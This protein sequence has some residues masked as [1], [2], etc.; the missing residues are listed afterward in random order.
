[1]NQ[2]AIVVKENQALVPVVGKISETAL[3]EIVNDFSNLPF[4][5]AVSL[6]ENRQPAE[7]RGYLERSGIVNDVNELERVVSASLTLVGNDEECCAIVGVLSPTE[8][9]H[10]VAV[11]ADVYSDKVKDLIFCDATDGAWVE[12]SKEDF[13]RILATGDKFAIARLKNI[14][15]N[16]DKDGPWAML[17]TEIVI[18]PES[19]YAYFSSVVSTDNSD[20]W[21][22]TALEAIGPE[23]LAYAAVTMPEIIDVCR[24]HYPLVCELLQAITNRGVDMARVAEDYFTLADKLKVELSAMGIEV[25]QKPLAA[26]INEFRNMGI[27]N[28][29]AAMIADDIIG[30]VDLDRLLAEGLPDD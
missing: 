8:I 23:L 16:G 4:K 5:K 17:K 14:S 20:E 2:L 12:I 21:K 1:M 27:N 15:T 18:H 30:D 10:V 3:M 29:T 22:E 7:I 13:D 11:S 26:R 25:D 6:L 28:P 9:G 19:V 24:R